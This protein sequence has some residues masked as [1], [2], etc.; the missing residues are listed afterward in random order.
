VQMAGST[1]ES[2]CVSICLMAHQHNIESNVIISL[3]SVRK[4]ILDTHKTLMFREF[5]CICWCACVCFIDNK[6]CTMLSAY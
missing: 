1:A 2:N 4:R 3:L 6:H 5:V